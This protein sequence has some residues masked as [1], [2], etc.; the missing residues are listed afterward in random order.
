MTPMI[1]MAVVCEFGG[2]RTGVF[3][4]HAKL[5]AVRLYIGVFQH[6]ADINGIK[7]PIGRAIP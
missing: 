3:M 7:T 1:A 2:A 4:Q 6:S 5:D